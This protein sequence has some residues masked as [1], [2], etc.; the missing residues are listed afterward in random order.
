MKH[1]YIA[2]TL[3]LNFNLMAEL[4]VSEEFVERFSSLPS[5]TDVGISPDG[6]MISVVAKMPNE[7]KGL[8]IFDANDLSLINTITFPNEEEVATYSWVNNERLIIRIGYYDKK[9]GRGSGGGREQQEKVG[10]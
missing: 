6:K 2:L 5:Y 7:K 10:N 1:L 8:T 3:I 4:G 9:S